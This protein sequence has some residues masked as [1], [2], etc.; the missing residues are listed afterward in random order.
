L[1]KPE[2]GTEWVWDGLLIRG[3]IECVVEGP[4]N[5]R[6]VESGWEAG[7]LGEVRRSVGERVRGGMSSL[8]KA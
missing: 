6:E 7:G 2:S 3:S 1:R 4:R 5:P 8:R